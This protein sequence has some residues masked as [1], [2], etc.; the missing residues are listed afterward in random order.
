MVLNA[1]QET[2]IAKSTIIYIYKNS[3]TIKVLVDITPGGQIIECST[4]PRDRDRGNSVMADKRFDVQA[5][6]AP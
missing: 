3:N 6:F 2:K 1:H 5:T 4:M